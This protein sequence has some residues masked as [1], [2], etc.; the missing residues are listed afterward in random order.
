MLVPLDETVALRLIRDAG[1]A[2]EPLPLPVATVQHFDASSSKSLLLA[3]I[4]RRGQPVRPSDTVGEVKVVRM[5]G[6]DE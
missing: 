3:Q 2:L 4:S 1:V 5:G 6:E